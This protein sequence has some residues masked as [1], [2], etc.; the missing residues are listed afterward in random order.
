[1]AMSTN[2]ELQG[3][4]VSPLES[5]HI[6]RINSSLS[7]DTTWYELIKRDHHQIYEYLLFLGAFFPKRRGYQ[8]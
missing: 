6:E 8:A 2:V 1:M 3:V 7:S 4:V 5:M